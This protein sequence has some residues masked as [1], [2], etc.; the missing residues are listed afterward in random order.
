MIITLLTDFGLSDTYVAE[1]KAALLAVAPTATLI[2]VTHGVPPGDLDT[3]RYLMSRTWKRFPEGTVHLV[4]VDPGVGSARLGLAVHFGGQYFV[5][6]DNGVL[7]S[8]LGADAT[9]VSLPEP[10]GAAPTF[11]GRDVFAPAAAR[12]ASGVPIAT[13]GPSCER[14]VRVTSPIPHVEG[15]A[16]VGAVVHVDRF[17]TLVSNVPSAHLE[18]ARAVEVGSRGYAATIGRT[19]ADVAPGELVAYAGSDGAVEVAVRDGS[20]AR[21]TGLTTG[22]RVRVIGRRAPSER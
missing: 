22:A 21:M 12:L 13:L 6:P 7:T 15:D 3:A 20:A 11:H 8:V 14:P 5:G 10:E 18:G 9:V 2:D 19:F 17:G 4:V 1:T 16:V